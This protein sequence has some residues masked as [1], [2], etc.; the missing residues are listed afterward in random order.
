M[1]PPHNNTGVPSIPGVPGVSGVQGVSGVNKE[2]TELRR[3]VDDLGAR[4]NQLREMLAERDDTIGKL[5]TLLNAGCLSNSSS[6]T[7]IVDAAHNS[8]V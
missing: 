3:T 5:V 8:D 2:E 4:V 7:H 6:S 1:S